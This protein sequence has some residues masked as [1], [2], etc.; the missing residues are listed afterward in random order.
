MHVH[1]NFVRLKSD[2]VFNWFTKKKRKYGFEMHPRLINFSRSLSVEQKGA[3]AHTFLMV[4][5]AD[6]ASLNLKMYNYIYDQFESIG[7]GI[8]SKYMQEYKTN[9]LAYSY[10][11]INSLSIDQKR[12]FAISLHGMMYEIGIK[13][14][15][16]HIQYYLALGQQTSN[17]YI[18]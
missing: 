16:K 5:K 13:P 7:F 2:R 3:M 17:P 6:D 9:D 10:T 18:K 8:K 15:F 11:K 1:C 12:W 14:S 4:L